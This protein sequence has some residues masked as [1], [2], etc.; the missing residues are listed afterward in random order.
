[1]LNYIWA[2]MIIVGIIFAAFTGTME[3]VSSSI[4][5]S[6]KEAIQLCLVMLGVVGMWT[7]VMK[8]AERTGLV[9]QLTK[10]L[11]PILRLFQELRTRSR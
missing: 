7:G 6:S 5:D 3:E 1:M 8:I 4:L 10:R 11:M 2:F 9:R